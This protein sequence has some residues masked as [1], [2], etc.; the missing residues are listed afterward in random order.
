[1]IR[2]GRAVDLADEMLGAVIGLADP[3]GVE[4]VGGEDVGAGI[5]E[6]LGDVARPARA[7]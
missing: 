6:A 7:G 3:V 2:G 5:G 1:M 4:A